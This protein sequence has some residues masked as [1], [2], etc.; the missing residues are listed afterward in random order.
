MISVLHALRGLAGSYLSCNCFRI[1][2]TYCT[3]GTID[4]KA[5][6][7]VRNARVVRGKMP[8][9]ATFPIIMKIRTSLR[10]VC[11][12]GVI[13]GQRAE[14]C[15]SWMHVFSPNTRAEI[16]CR[17]GSGR[18]KIFLHFI[19]YIGGNKF[20]LNIQVSLLCPMVH[21]A[22]FHCASLCIWWHEFTPYNT[23]F[24]SVRHDKL[25]H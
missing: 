16:S 15:L 18:A 9:G 13:L 20:S 3:V 23:H 4:M 2:Q 7:E 22:S 12:L 17:A 24:A 8:G 1:C 19:R 25:L 21:L 5:R 6:D 14:G 11:G 10:S